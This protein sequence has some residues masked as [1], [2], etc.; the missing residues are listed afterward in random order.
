[1]LGIG[2]VRANGERVP[3]AEGLHRAGLQP[4]RLHTKEGLALINGTQV[5]TALALAGPFGA[6][7]LISPPPV[8]APQAVE[9]PP[10][11]RL[12]LA[13]ALPT[14]PGPPRRNRPAP[15]QTEGVSA[16][17]IRDA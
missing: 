6:Q 3:A 2:Y 9:P 11:S 15:G 5:S 16:T 1:M 12:P 8:A 14:V 7:A 17:A 13:A 4:I 10:G